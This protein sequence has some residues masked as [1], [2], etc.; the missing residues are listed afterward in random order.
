MTK[1]CK[2]GS[3]LNTSSSSP[4]SSL[5]LTSLLLPLACGTIIRKAQ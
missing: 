3:N 4:Y 5:K 2:A 1:V